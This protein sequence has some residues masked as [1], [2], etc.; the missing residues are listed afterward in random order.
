LALYRWAFATLKGIPLEQVSAS[1]YYVTTNEVVT[2][3]PLLNRDQ[4][5]ERWAKVVG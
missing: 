2:P 3:E 1:L 4:L 5:L